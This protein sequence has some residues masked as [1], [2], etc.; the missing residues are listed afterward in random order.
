MLFV[1]VF[2]LQ[3]HG[4]SD[5]FKIAH[6]GR[7]ISRSSDAGLLGVNIGLVCT[8]I[9]LGTRRSRLNM[10]RIIDDNVIF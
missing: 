3:C 10:G 5:V 6:W 1:T 8:P 2:W 7:R 9:I 4:R